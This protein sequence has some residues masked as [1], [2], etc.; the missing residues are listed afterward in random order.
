MKLATV[1]AFV[2][3]LVLASTAFAQTISFDFDRS[4]SFGAYKTYA[5]VAGTN[6][7]DQLV[8][9]RLVSAVDA[10]LAMKGL[11]QVESGE[12][13]VLV[14]YHASFDKDLQVTGFGTGWG[15]YR[16]G[17]YRSGTVRAEEILVGTM[18]VDI[19]DAA[20]STIVWRGTAT[21]DIDVDAKPEK[22]DKNIAKTAEK[23]FKHY[24]PA[25]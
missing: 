16:F 10:Q 17:A 7:P 13:D 12:A 5:W 19:V 8:H 24:P 2:L 14:A 23:L 9:R 15:G 1:S 4:I 18:I 21:K 22:R 11:R 6:V 25:Q 3:S 20:T